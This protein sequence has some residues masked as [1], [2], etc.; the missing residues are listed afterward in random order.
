M[1]VA[2]VKTVYEQWAKKQASGLYCLYG[3]ETLKA[4]EFL[5][6]LKSVL[7]EAAAEMG[8]FEW[9][10]MD[11]SEGYT[12]VEVI[13][14]VK[15]LTF[16]VVGKCV[17]VSDA[18]MFEGKGDSKKSESKAAGSK[19]SEFENLIE[20]LALPPTALAELPWVVVL[21]MKDLDKRKKTTKKLLE[22][23]T[24]VECAEVP[25]FERGKWIQFLATKKKCII[26]ERDEA[27]LIALEPWSLER[28]ER[29]L[30]VILL[31]AVDESVDESN[32]SSEW[33]RLALRWNAQDFVE[34]YFDN[35]E[36]LLRAYL[37][38]LKSRP[39]EAIPLIGLISWNLR[40]FVPESGAK[41]PPFIVQKL[42]RWSATW[43][44]EKLKQAHE[45]LLNADFS[46]KQ[47]QRVSVGI[48]QDLLPPK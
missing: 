8:N 28:I 3:P 17:V 23:A 9:R 41:R 20:E 33:E 48:L 31:S 21:W 35:N 5:K 44:T 45:K 38:D 6:K 37:E 24:V 30:E 10:R 18:Q 25:E 34:A 43:D 36:P 2:E 7:E 29:E 46:L 4:R 22:K 1:P 16:G 15:S 47:T 11:A 32:G 40:Q 13:D 27:R 14:E 39:E 12:P 42:K 19:S 26:G